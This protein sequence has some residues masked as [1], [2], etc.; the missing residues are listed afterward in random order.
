MINPFITKKSINRIYRSSIE[1]LYSNR[2]YQDLSTGFS[3]MLSEKDNHRNFF[4]FEPSGCIAESLLC[5]RNRYDLNYKIE[6]TIDRAMYSM[7]VYGRAYIYIQPHYVQQ[8][9]DEDKKVPT[10]QIISALDIGEI[11]GI[12]KQKNGNKC[13]FYNK[14]FDGNLSKRELLTDGL[15]SLNIKELGYRKKYFP[16]LLKKLGKCDVISSGLMMSENAEG[17]DY[18]T[19]SKKKRL[20]FLKKT[21]SI[22][23]TFG[24]DDL[25]DSYILYR[26]IL[27]DKFRIRALDFIVD[28]INEGLSTCLHNESPGEL[29]AC[30]RRL[31]YDDIWEQFMRG[32]ITVTG[33]TN[34][35][36]KG[37]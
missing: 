13:I 31:D 23:W 22:G 34:L 33:L 19:H 5:A 18:I 10:K 35:L 1:N 8:E 32:K 17:Y 15:I 4:S 28:K 24:N 30:I 6:Q 11:K 9:L 29:V 3:V 20:E 14:G 12:I 7:M 27:L 25:S 26:R 21:K 36:Y 2:F 37:Y 16:N